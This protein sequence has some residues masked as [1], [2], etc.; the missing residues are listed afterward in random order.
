MLLFLPWNFNLL[1]SSLKGLEE[2]NGGNVDR[3]ERLENLMGFD[4][5]VF[6]GLLFNTL[7]FIFFV[8]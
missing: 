8:N 4:I 7:E 5:R 3:A 6:L 1:N 2:M